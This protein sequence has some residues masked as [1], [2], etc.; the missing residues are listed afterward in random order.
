MSGR[1][2]YP[3]G[4]AGAIAVTLV[5]VAAHGTDHPQ[6][7]LTALAGT[8]AAVAT[9]TTA[10]ATLAT[11]AVAWALHAGFVL[12]RRGELVYTPASAAAA[13]VLCCAVVVAY[14]IAVAARYARRGS[15]APLAIPAPRDV[16]V[17]RAARHVL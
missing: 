6:W 2:G 11:A 15:A 12:G 3:L 9:V 10:R 13:A 7:T 14:V 8:S 5:A 17:L 4:F 1:L 16:T